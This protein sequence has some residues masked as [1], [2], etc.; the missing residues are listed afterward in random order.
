MPVN[1][2]EPG[3]EAS[4]CGDGVPLPE[5]PA[6]S[7]RGRRVYFCLGRGDD[8]HGWYPG[9]QWGQ[10][11]TV[12][13]TRGYGRGTDGDRYRSSQCDPAMP[14]WYL[15][16]DGVHDDSDREHQKLG[17]DPPPSEYP[18]ESAV[19]TIMMVDQHFTV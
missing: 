5:L 19:D 3:D 18:G 14:G 4:P 7:C 1:D 2:R 15:L 6:R 17:G 12:F 9:P 10:V 11:Q 8:I 13:S 16:G